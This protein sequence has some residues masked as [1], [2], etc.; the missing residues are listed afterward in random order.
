VELAKNI[1]NVG[2]Y[3][4]A[5]STKLQKVTLGDKVEQINTPF[6]GCTNLKQF[7]ADKK[8][9]GYYAVNDVLY[10]KDKE[11]TYMKCYPAAKRGD[12][13]EFP[14]GVNGGGLCFTNCR[15]LNK[16]VY[17]KDSTMGQDFYGCHNLTVVLPDVVVNPATGSENDS[18]DGKWEPFKNC[19]NFILQGKKNPFMQSY[20]VSKGFTYSIV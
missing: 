1:S 18:Y 15:Y 16:V 6:I 14:A 17:A 5:H 11:K 9:T 13:Y 20:A 12:S 8:E 3:A 19:T 10:Y 2:L 7:K 4:F